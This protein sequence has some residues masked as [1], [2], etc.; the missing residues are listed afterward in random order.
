MTTEIMQALTDAGVETIMYRWQFPV[1]IV[2]FD[3]DGEMQAVPEAHLSDVSWAERQRE[4]KVVAEF[5]NADEL[6]ECID[7]A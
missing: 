7:A 5:S 2:Q 6:C 3:D 1:A 4:Y